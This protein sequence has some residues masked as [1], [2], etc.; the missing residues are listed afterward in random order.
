[1]RLTEQLAGR[2]RRLVTAVC[3]LLLVAGLAVAGYAVSTQQGDPP[4]LPRTA[5]A[6][7][8]RTDAAAETAPTEAASTEREESTASSP[9]APGGPPEGPAALP[10]SEPVSISIPGINVASVVNPIGL[11]DDGALDVPTGDQYDEAAWFTGSPTPG[12][13]GPAVV[14]GHVTSSGSTPSVFFELAALTAGDRVSV[15]RA[16]GSVAT[17]EVYRVQSYAKNDFP[18]GV[19]YGNTEGPELRLITCGGEYDPDGRRHLDNTVV[20]ARLITVS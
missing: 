14:E 3:G 12:E 2:G 8:T 1:M 6:D 7:A 10:A 5:A 11:A 19:V 20:Y 15:D 13:I 17:F 16:D 9:D 4:E 18:T